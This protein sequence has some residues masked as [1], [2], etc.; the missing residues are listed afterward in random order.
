V[1]LWSNG[2]DSWSGVAQMP[3]ESPAGEALDAE[4]VLGAAHASLPGAA[5][6]TDST[7]IDVSVVPGGTATWALR[8]GSVVLDRLEDIPYQTAL[9]NDSG[10]DG[11]PQPITVHQEL[12]WLGS[13]VSWVFDGVDDNVQMGNVLAKDRTDAFSYGVW[14]AITSSGAFN[15]V[16]HTSTVPRGWTLVMSAGQLFAQM[17]ANPGI[18]QSA[19]T[20]TFNDGVLHFALVEYDGSSGSA[21]LNIR[22]DDVLVAQSKTGA[23]LVAT[24]VSTGPLQISGF[25]GGAPFTPG[26]LQH[27]SV[28]NRTLVAAERTALYAAGNPPDISALSFTSALQGWWKIDGTDATGAGGVVDYGPSGFDGT[29]NGGLGGA[30]SVSV[31]SLPVRGAALWQPLQPGAN[32]FPLV[33]NGTGA[34]PSYRVLPNAGLANAAA[35]TYKG[36]NTGSAG[37][38]VDI[39]IANLAGAG[40]TATG[41]VL[42]VI[43][44]T[45]IAVNA[46]DIQRAALTGAITAA[47][48]SNATAFGALAAKSVLANATNSSAVPA[49]LAGTAAFQYLRVNSANTGLEWAVLS[50]SAFPTMAAGSFLANITAGVAVPTAHGL[51][52]FA[53]AGLTYT[54]VTGIMAVGA[55]THVTVNADDVTLNLATLIPAIDSPSVVADGT[56]LERAALTGAI[57]AAQD[58]NA[59]VFGTAGDGLQGTG[60]ASLALIGS[61]NNDVLVRSG[62]V[63]AVDNLGS[64]SMLANISEGP[65]STGAGDQTARDSLLWLLSSPRLRVFDEDFQGNLTTFTGGNYRWS[66]VSG[67]AGVSLGGTNADLV[68]GLILQNTSPN[69]TTRG[70]YCLGVNELAANFR[71]ETWRYIG[72]K[73]RTTASSIVAGTGFQCGLVNSFAAYGAGT[74]GISSTSIGVWWQYRTDVSSGEWAAGTRQGGS[75]SSTASGTVVAGSVNY[76]LEIIR[77]SSGALHYYLDGALVRSDSTAGTLALSGQATLYFTQIGSTTATRNIQVD[78][79]RVLSMVP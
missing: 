14:F 50:L 12:D 61:S 3:A 49:A 46:N 36:N 55:G 51:A 27:F 40:M 69:G 9:G 65:T 24:T 41:S 1:V 39:P 56:V 16:G 28:W 59:T 62:G 53:G 66:I 10:G 73:I 78:W 44:S 60:T 19:T 43:G 38:M 63:W 54:N 18:I 8:D 22:V 47:A 64:G 48:N 74:A 29:A 17:R 72:M 75:D 58:S 7:E 2:K 37:P 31:G 45:S 42:N 26:V 15:I 35:D 57:T 5:V 30:V 6:A 77:T 13:G 52:T 34:L 76:L 67:F 20:G 32:S 71:L 33:A 11:P 21:G 79:V 23:A 25:G 70:V 68:G 4:Y